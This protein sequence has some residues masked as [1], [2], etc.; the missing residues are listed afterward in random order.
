MSRRDD[1][2]VCR[3][4]RPGRTN[5]RLSI[6]CGLLA[7]LLAAPAAA[8]STEALCEI[9]PAGSD[10]LDKMGPCTFSQRQGHVTILRDD[11]VTHDLTP[12]GD[13]PGNFLDQ[14]GHAAYRQS[15]LG[16]EGLIFRLRDE[17][18]FVYWDSGALDPET[19][20]V[21]LTPISGPARFLLYAA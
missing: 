1:V 20:T 15:G 16:S 3:I 19:D 11:G 5:V 18:V 14:D 4:Q 6:I 17:S 13:T 8:D 7:A 2:T 12:T 9:Y 21:T 10:T